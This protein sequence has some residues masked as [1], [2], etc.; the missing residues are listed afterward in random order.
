MNVPLTAFLCVERCSTHGIAL[1]SA[2]VDRA[3]DLIHLTPLSSLSILRR[4]PMFR[5]NNT[6]IRALEVNDLDTLYSWEQDIELSILAGWTGLLAKSAFIH[7]FEQRINE[8]K[9]DMRYFA[10]D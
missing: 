3:V 6:T 10:V 4:Q 1:P 7:K 9:D 2:P 8:P 5:L